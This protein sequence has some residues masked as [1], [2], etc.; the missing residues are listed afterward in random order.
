MEFRQRPEKQF[1]GEVFKM[2]ASCLKFLKL[3]CLA[4]EDM[5]L[6]I[7]SQATLKFSDLRIRF[8]TAQRLSPRLPFLL[9][10]K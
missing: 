10:P 2:D 8:F 1:R 5:E 4:K 6:L 7:K 3:R 9:S